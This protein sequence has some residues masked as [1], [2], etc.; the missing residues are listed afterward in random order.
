MTSATYNDYANHIG[1]DAIQAYENLNSIE[2]Y[3]LVKEYLNSKNS[4]KT[5]KDTFLDKAKEDVVFGLSAST[6][7]VITASLISGI[8]SYIPYILAGGMIGNTASTC[9]ETFINVSESQ[10]YRTWRGQKSEEKVSQVFKNFLCEDEILKN[11][12][13]PFSFLIP[14]IPVRGKDKQIYERSVII[15]RIRNKPPGSNAGLY[16]DFT[17]EELVFD[18]FHFVKVMERI[19]IVVEI[20]LKRLDLEPDNIRIIKD[21]L[22]SYKKTKDKFNKILLRELLNK[23]QEKFDKMEE[24]ENRGRNDQKNS[25]KYEKMYLDERKILTEAFKPIKIY[26]EED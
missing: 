17:E 20:E 7:M 26:V 14:E 19:K 21:G 16:M 22:M 4:Y 23:S 5:I 3:N 1:N 9:K 18:V 10:D 6:A 8:W 13:C 25:D 2:A 15:Q 12:I 11:F 24:E